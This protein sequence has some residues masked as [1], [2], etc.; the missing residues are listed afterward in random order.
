M[1]YIFN[2]LILLCN[3]YITRKLKNKHIGD[4][5]FVGITW[6][7]LVLI[8]GLRKNTVGTDSKSYT[9]LFRNI[10]DDNITNLNDKSPLF[11]ILLKNISKL[12]GKSD[13]IYFFTTGIVIITFVIIAIIKSR[14]DIRNGIILYYVM[15]YLPSLN[16]TRNYMAIAIFFAGFFMLKSQNK[17]ETIIGIL[18]CVSAIFIHSSAIIGIPILVIVN[19]NLSK[20]RN[21]IFI[22]SSAVIAILAYKV[23]IGYFIILFPIYTNTI[24]SIN[25]T[26][27][28]SARVFQLSILICF[29]QSIII[30]KKELYNIGGLLN[31]YTQIITILLAI[32]LG[33]FIV[34]GNTWYFQR[35]IIYMEILSI[36]LFVNNNRIKNKY[37][38][39]TKVSFVITIMFCFVYRI[40]RNL[41]DVSPYLFFWQ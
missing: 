20:K 12:L 39:V 8:M 30:K 26:V 1:F 18:L 13:Q 27:G 23:F 31:D 6:L 19:T 5:F 34:G 36:P 24:N 29:V 37:R 7:Q 11:V 32:E 28:A 38:Q 41:G 9:V 17:K 14:I 35:F 2:F 40:L 22:I 21:R 4:C 15:F 3:S 25:D 16:A 33:M 10:A